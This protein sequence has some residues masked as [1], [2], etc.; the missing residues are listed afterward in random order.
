MEKGARAGCFN[1]KY[2]ECSFRQPRLNIQVPLLFGLVFFF[3]FF[4]GAGIVE[5]IEFEKLQCFAF[6]VS[7]GLC[8]DST[9]ISENRDSIPL[10]HSLKFVLLKWRYTF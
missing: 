7:I 10:F 6:Y 3:F 8:N 9:L 1:G 4:L 5:N 2:L